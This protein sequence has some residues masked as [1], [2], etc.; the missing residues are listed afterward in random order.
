MTSNDASRKRRHPTR[1]TLPA[2]CARDTGIYRAVGRLAFAAIVAVLLAGCQ[3][4]Q[5]AFEGPD[6]SN[7]TRRIE[8]EAL[9]EATALGTAQGAMGIA[10]SFDRSRA[11]S[12]LAMGA[13]Q[14]ARSAM[15]IR[16]RQ[17]LQAQVDK[18]DAAFLR[19]HGITDEDEPQTPHK[20][21]ACADA[22][23]GMCRRRRY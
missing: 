13:G 16:A 2:I 17:R 7:E 14:A 10:A 23:P 22:Y 11:S 3:T 1:P 20:T 5:S 6:Y 12:L 21:D 19:K 15:M 8:K 4:Q 18:D 9:A